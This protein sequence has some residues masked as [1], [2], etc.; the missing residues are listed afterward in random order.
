MSEDWRGEYERVREQFRGTSF[1]EFQRGAWFD[2]L[3]HWLLL[4][5]AANVDAAY[6]GAKYPGASPNNQARKAIGLASKQNALAGGVSAAAVT[7]LQLSSVGPQ[8]AITVPA[9]GLAIAADVGYSTRVQ[10]RTAYDLSMIHGAPLAVDDIEDCHLLFCVAMGMKMSEMIGDVAKTIGPQVIAYNVRSLL[11]SGVRSALQ[12]AMKRIGGVVLARKLTER[13]LMRV[14][15]PG[16]SVA[17]SSGMN[18][19]F[20]K[21]M[22]STCD[23]IMRRRGKVVQPLIRIFGREPLFSKTLVLKLMIAVLESGTKEG[24][25]EEQMNAL[26]YSQ[27]F[28]RL[29]DDELKAMDT[30]FERGVQHVVDE[31]PAASPQIVSYLVEYLLVASAL[32]PDNRHDSSYVESIGLISEGAAVHSS[33]DELRGRIKEYRRELLGAT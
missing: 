22:L 13:A 15:V 1:E 21:G 6:I 2:R 23:R 32:Y 25:S 3:V 10:L 4:E 9:V 19:G 11:R 30:Y 18:Y 14:M 31:L 24:W 5:Y 28:L 26:R 16:L 7:G 20:T 29:Q 33:S 12:A 8:A 27:Q 17:I